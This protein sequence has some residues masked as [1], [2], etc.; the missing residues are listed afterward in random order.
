[1][2]GKWAQIQNK[3]QTTVVDS[4][5]VFE[6]L[7]FPGTRLKTSYSR[8]TTWHGFLGNIQRTT[9]PQGITLSGSCC[10]R[11]DTSSAKTIRVSDIVG[12]C[13]LY[14][15]T[16]SVTFIQKNNDTQK[17][18]QRIIWVTSQTS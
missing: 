18:K 13:V 11:E 14:S 7:T 17:S 1:M 4:E 6:P 2:W 3:T 12:Q 5:K 8:M 16:D 15:D 10:L 9:F